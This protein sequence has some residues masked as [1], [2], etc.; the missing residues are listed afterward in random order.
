M[1]GKMSVVPHGARGPTLSLA[2]ATRS[3]SRAGGPIRTLRSQG[4]TIKGGSSALD[5]PP[6]RTTPVAV[7]ESQAIQEGLRHVSPA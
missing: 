1:H 3:E 4:V 5:C 2:E 6:I 7:A